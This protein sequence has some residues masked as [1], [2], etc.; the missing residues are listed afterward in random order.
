[1]IS[2][3][4][5]LTLIACCLFTS[6]NSSVFANGDSESMRAAGSSDQPMPFN[7]MMYGNYKKMMHTRDFS[8]KVNL[9]DIAFDPGTYAVGAL[10]GRR[11]EITV[12][13]GEPFISFGVSPSETR[14]ESDS[15]SESAALLGV[16]HNKDWS[17][18]ELSRDYEHEEFERFLVD[19]ARREGFDASKP[20]IFKMK[21]S[22]LNYKIHVLAVDGREETGASAV[23]GG[24]QAAS[25]KKHGQSMTVD[26]VGFYAGQELSGVLTHPGEYFH[27][28]VV[29]S[30]RSIS[31]HVDDYTAAKGSILY[32]PKH[33]RT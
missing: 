25:F 6:S 11:G 28:H 19:L 24:H 16:A 9:A 10:S 12:L 3:R 27:V 30:Q 13:D 14:F 20:F 8:S 17:E 31:A 29:D 33:P 22:I 26:L 5:V 15:Q 1:M 2:N 23:P 4:S 7:M 21:G 18:V 32:F